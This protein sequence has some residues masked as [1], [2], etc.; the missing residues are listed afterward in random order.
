M[1]QVNTPCDHRG[2]HLGRVERSGQA[3]SPVRR[4]RDDGLDVR[5]PRG[6]FDDIYEPPAED[7]LQLLSSVVLVCPDQRTQSWT[8][9]P[10][11]DRPGQPGGPSSKR[12]AP[13]LR[14]LVLRYRCPTRRTGRL[15]LLAFEESTAGRAKV[16]GIR[17]RPIG[18]SQ[19]HGREHQVLDCCLEPFDHTAIILDGFLDSVEKAPHFTTIIR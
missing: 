18:T 5:K 8:V 11:T 6:C 9:R 3:M 15:F 14:H 16:L 10:H 12:A 19:A 2:K 1:R 7:R 4:D 13:P 17:P